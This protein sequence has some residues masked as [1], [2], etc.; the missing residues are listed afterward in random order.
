[1]GS[2]VRGARGARGARAGRRA[3]P[4]AR[5]RAAAGDA[6]RERARARPGR[7]RVRPL[8]GERLAPSSELAVTVRDPAAR[9]RRPAQRHLAVGDGDVR[10]V[11]LRLSEFGDPGHERDRVRE[12]TELER[13]LERSVDLAPL[14]HSGD[15]RSR[16]RKD[17]SPKDTNTRF[18]ALDERKARTP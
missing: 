7:A 2:R 9:V 1:R 13:P 10:M 16:R 6:G 5:M 4:R 3:D 14:A 17:A 11:V 15:Y 12:G 8:L 18:P